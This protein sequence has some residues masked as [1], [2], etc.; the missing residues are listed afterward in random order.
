MARPCLAYETPAQG[1]PQ[2]DPPVCLRGTD[3]YAD[4]SARACGISLTGRLNE[5]VVTGLDPVIHLLRKKISQR[6]MDARI[7]SGH[8]QRV[9]AAHV[10]KWLRT[11]IPFQFSYS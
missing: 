1:V 4:R 7:K 2:C 8:D 9:F 5:I 6:W 10:K 3:D 11:L